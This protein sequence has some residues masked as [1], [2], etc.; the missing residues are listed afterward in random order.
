MTYYDEDSIDI[1]YC[2]R[3]GR[4]LDGSV[5]PDQPHCH[6]CTDEETDR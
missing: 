3:C 2:T 4:M 5:P 1:G 6:D